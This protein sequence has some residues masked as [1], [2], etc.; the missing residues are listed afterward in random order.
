M[1]LY[2]Y[3]CPECSNEFDE[4]ALMADRHDVQCPKCSA[5]AELVF[6]PT[7]LIFFHEG[8]YEHLGPEPVYVKSMDQLKRICEERGLTSRYVEDSR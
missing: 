8:W 4:F 1:P 7:S 2:D 3:T 6:R 5:K